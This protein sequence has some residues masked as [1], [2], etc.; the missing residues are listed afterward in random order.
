LPDPGLDA[1]VASLG[2]PEACLDQPLDRLSTGER[3]RLALARAVAD[4]PKVLL[5]DEPT[6]A[7]DDESSRLVEDLIRSW[8]GAGTIIILVSHDTE[9]V[10]RHADARLQLAKTQAPAKGAT[11]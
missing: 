6:S 1:L 7:L 10:M 11:V 9:L 3:Q 5:L 4:Q 2:L 8:L